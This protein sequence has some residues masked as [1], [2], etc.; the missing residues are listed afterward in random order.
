MRHAIGLAFLA[1]LVLPACTSN[2]GATD[3][4]TSGSSGENEALF[5]TWTPTLLEYYRE[6]AWDEYTDDIGKMPLESIPKMKYIRVESKDGLLTLTRDGKI[7]IKEKGET[8]EGTFKLVAA[9]DGKAFKGIDVSITPPGQ[10]KQ[11]SLAIYQ[12]EG[13]TLKIAGA[14]KGERPTTFDPTQA[15]VS[16]FKRQKP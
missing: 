11:E 15:T 16:T 10:E 5:G 12:I 8:V 13:D 9:G 3:R 4:E 1:A 7:T 14:Q 2:K 6:K